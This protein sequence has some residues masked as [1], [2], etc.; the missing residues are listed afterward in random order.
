MCILRAETIPQGYRVGAGEHRTLSN[1]K[2]T[3]KVP[4]L[5]FY[6]TV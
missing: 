3:V 1:L 5:D 2:A 4:A 6:E